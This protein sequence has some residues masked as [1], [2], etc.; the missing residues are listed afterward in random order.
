MCVQQL[1]AI[2][3]IS[4]GVGAY[5][6]MTLEQ[7]QHGTGVRAD[8]RHQT[9][10]DPNVMPRIVLVEEICHYGNDPDT[11]QQPSQWKSLQCL[12]RKKAF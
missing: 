5:I 4:S 10:D 2:T 11:K 9:P 3:S 8:L 6:V 1:Q 7:K 12:R